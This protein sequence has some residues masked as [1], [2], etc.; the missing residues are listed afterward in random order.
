MGIP[1]PPPW[2][3]M[4][5]VLSFAGN[6][7]DIKEIGFLGVS[8]L[9]GRGEDAGCKICDKVRSPQPAILAT[10]DAAVAD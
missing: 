4:S 7:Q 6:I 10:R 3:I 8:L 2:V 9:T 5:F 1:L